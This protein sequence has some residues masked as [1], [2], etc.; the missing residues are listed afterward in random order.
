MSLTKVSYSMIQGEVANVL[1]YGAKGDGTTDDTAAFNLAIAT[2]KR[3]YVPLTTNGYVVKDIGV[4]TNMIIEGEKAGISS[5]PTLIVSTNNSAAFTVTT[6]AFQIEIINFIITAA[7]GVTGARAYKQ[8]DKSYYTAYA[9]FTGIETS[10][11]LAVS[12]DLFPIFTV[13]R[14][15][16]DGYIDAALAQ[17]HQAINVTPSTWT[18]GNQ[19]NINKIVDC[20]FWGANSSNCNGTNAYVAMLD[21]AYGDTWSIENTDFEAC[22]IQ[23]VRARGIYNFAF[24]NARFEAISDYKVVSSDITPSNPVGS[25]MCFTNCTALMGSTLTTGYFAYIGTASFIEINDCFFLQIPSNVFLSTSTTSIRNAFN[26]NVVGAG[27]SAFLNNVNTVTFAGG[28]MLVNNGSDTGS[29]ATIQNHGLIQS[30][31]NFIGQNAISISTAP[32]FVAVTIGTGGLCF[33]NGFNVSNGNQGWW[34]V[35]WS[36]STSVTTIA[37]NNMTGLTVAFT[38]VS[39]QLKMNTTSGTLTVNATALL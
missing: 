33:V 4:V 6:Q 24:R 38:I 16:R 18:Q 14:D 11:K 30:D 32:I 3:V 26:V 19:S 15:C 10:S 34:L 35:A 5:G 29:G 27:A 37:S 39:N 31:G 12:Y 8:L 36:N 2:G 9:R 13:W 17:G 22:N 28:K 7:T 25:S 20:S 1:D 23:A 21:I